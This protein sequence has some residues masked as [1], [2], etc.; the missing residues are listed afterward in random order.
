MVRKL[1]VVRQIQDLRL[2]FLEIHRLIEFAAL[3]IPQC[4]LGERD[5]ALDLVA[6]SA[7][8]DDALRQAQ[9]QLPARW[10]P[11][12]RFRCLVVCWTVAR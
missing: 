4:A 3:F 10:G 9:R 7:V 1:T 6:E 11:G 8:T 12:C 5:G 2:R